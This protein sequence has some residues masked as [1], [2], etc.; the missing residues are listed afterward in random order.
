MPTQDELDAADAVKNF[1]HRPNKELDAM[2]SDDEETKKPIISRA[3]TIQK[4][5]DTANSGFRDDPSKLSVGATTVIEQG[6]TTRA[7]AAQDGDM[8]TQILRIVEK[9]IGQKSIVLDEKFKYWHQ[10][11]NNTIDSKFKDQSRSLLEQLLQLQSEMSTQ[12]QNHISEI[13]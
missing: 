5:P 8:E 7:P 4:L 11:V 9:I 6:S 13:H 3:T 12:H 10:E 1:Q 2:G